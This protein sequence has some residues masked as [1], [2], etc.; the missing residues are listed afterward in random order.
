MKNET[1]HSFVPLTTQ[2]VNW[3]WQSFAKRDVLYYSAHPTVRSSDYF[4]VT[5]T[6]SCV[7]GPPA[8]AW[9]G[10][11]V[12]P[13]TWAL[14][15]GADQGA[16]VYS[17][18]GFEA[19]GSGWRGSEGGWKGIGG[20]NGAMGGDRRLVPRSLVDAVA[21][22]F[23]K[24]P[25]S[26]VEFILPARRRG[27]EEE[28]DVHDDRLQATSAAGNMTTD[29]GQGTLFSTSPVAGTLGPALGEA[30]PSRLSFAK[31]SQRGDPPYRRIFANKEILRRSEYFEY[32]LEG[33]YK[34]TTTG[35]DVSTFVITEQDFPTDLT[36]EDR[37]SLFLLW[38]IC[39][40]MILI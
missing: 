20:G 25:Y 4:V 26:D 17:P 36:R 23:N 6:V 16:F 40:P 38:T 9:L 33:G 13:A 35:T 30:S 18:S 32:M 27:L 1:Y 28:E 7:A 12:P 14:E 34:E 29:P 11:N 22:T 31:Q 21:R 19:G 8:G 37:W 10:M 3:G 15:G 39:C 5:C 2:T 24:P